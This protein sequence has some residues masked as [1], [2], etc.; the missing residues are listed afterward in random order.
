MRIVRHARGCALALA[1]CLA[2]AASAQDTSTPQERAQWVELARKLESAPLDDSLNQQADA[3]L[4]RLMS[5]QD[6]QL[7]LCVPL[8]RQLN[9]MNYL[10]RRRLARQYMLAGGAF[11]IENPGR[12]ADSRALNLSALESVLKAYQA[13]LKQKPDARAAQLDDLVKKQNQGKLADA[14]KPCS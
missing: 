2:C 9:G 7:A 14:L 13:I 4:Q 8:L 10:Y 1:L 3:A 5:A 11:V 6:L 12:A